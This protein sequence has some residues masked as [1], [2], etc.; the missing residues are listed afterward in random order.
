MI[1][2]NAPHG[3]LLHPLP[4]AGPDEALD[5]LLARGGVRIERIV[6]T[7]Q[8]SPP[9]FWYDQAEDEFVLLLSGSATLRF[10]DGRTLDLNP[11]VWVDLPAHCRHRVETT[12]AD[13][14]TVWLT[15][16]WPSSEAKT[17]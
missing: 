8:S 5:T 4:P 6:S 17:S 16:F 7:G 9:D 1:A 10:D 12:A 11:G 14:P 2:M 15:V 13:Q 3:N